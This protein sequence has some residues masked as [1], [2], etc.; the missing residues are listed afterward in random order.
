VAICLECSLELIVGLLGILKAGGAYV[1][2]DP[3]YPAER[4][5]F[6][7]EDTGAHVLLTSRALRDRLPA[8]NAS[9]VY[10]DGRWKEI[11][12]YPKSTPQNLTTITNLIYIIYTSGSTGRPK[13]VLVEH[14]GM[15]N[16]VSQYRDLYGNIQGDRISQ[17]ANACFDSMGSEVWPA[18]SSGQPCISLR[19]ECELILN[20]CSIG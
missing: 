1:P 17:F 3:V 13:G 4:L 16:L 19:R 9:T 20:S 15:V 7:L 8:T 2:M 12:H 5:A 11:D 10:L 6:M 18:L 14:A